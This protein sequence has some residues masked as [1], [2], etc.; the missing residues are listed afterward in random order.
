MEA[1]VAVVESGGF[2]AA[3]RNT[4]STRAQ[5]NKLVHHLEEHLAT[6]L[7]QRTTRQVSPSETGRAYYAQC[8]RLLAELLEIEA[9]VMELHGQPTGPIRVNA[10]MTFGT[11]YLGRILASFCKRYPKLQMQLTLN[12]RFVDTIEEGY[13]LTLRI[14][15]VKAVAGLACRQLVKVVGYVVAAPGYLQEQGTPTT[16][17]EL[18]AHRFLHYG[19]PSGARE[20]LDSE[21]SS[22]KLRYQPTFSTNNGE[23]LQ[24]MAIEGMGI[25]ILPH[26]IVQD[27]LKQGQLVRILPNWWKPVGYLHALYPEH[28]SL[29]TK[30]RLLLAHLEANV[31]STC[32]A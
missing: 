13:D 14:G 2:A 24:D 11:M 1:F 31:P 7:L 12:D 17:E 5:V 20:V 8:K 9:E 22:F 4:G 16:P 18:E 27:A 30:T 28:R 10:P 32:P 3:A 26:F 6:R 21:T 25:T 15:E 19:N 23:V 29:S